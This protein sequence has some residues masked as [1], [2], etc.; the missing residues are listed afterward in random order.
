MAGKGK[1]AAF[2][3]VRISSSMYS[4]KCSFSKLMEGREKGFLLEYGLDCET[5]IHCHVNFG[6]ML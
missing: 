4:E 5:W 2:F 3:P 1:K 6:K